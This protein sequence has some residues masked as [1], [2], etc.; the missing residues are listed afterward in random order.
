M[1]A[2]QTKVAT[3]AATPQNS[4]N[5]VRVAF[6]IGITGHRTLSNDQAERVEKVCRS[7]LQ[8]IET[9][10]ASVVSA[11][12]PGYSNQPP[13]VRAISC[14]AAGSDQILAK[15][16]TALNSEPAAKAQFEVCAILPFAAN[17][18]RQDFAQRECVKDT[19][20]D[21][22]ALLAAAAHRTTL[23]DDRST[24]DSRLAA[25]EDAGRLMISIC[26]LLISVRGPTPGFK[27]GGTAQMT[28]EA[29]ASGLPVVSINLSE[30]IEVFL[31]AIDSQGQFR[32][33]AF[34]TVAIDRI[35]RKV[36]EP[37]RLRSVGAKESAWKVLCKELVDLPEPIWPERLLAIGYRLPWAG[38]HVLARSLRLYKPQL[39][40]NESKVQ[41][42]S[43]SLQ[44]RYEQ[45]GAIS[46]HYAIL[47]RGSFMLNYVL[48]ATA[49]TF[50][51]LQ[52]ATGSH[53]YLW[54]MAEAI[55]L[56]LLL[57]NFFAGRY[58][59]W[60]DRFGDFRFLTEQLRQIRILGPLGV[61]LP[62]IQ[63][64]DEVVKGRDGWINWY[65]R[66]ML[67]NCFT[68]D[69]TTV[70]KCRWVIDGW[71]GKQI[72]YHQD[73]SRNRLG[74][75]RALTMCALAFFTLAGLACIVHLAHRVPEEF[76][77]WL[78]LIAAAAPAWTAVCHSI[79]IQG[80]FQTIAER[81]EAVGEDLECIRRDLESALHSG[82]LTNGMLCSKVVEASR[83]MLYEVAG[84]RRV[85]QMHPV[86]PP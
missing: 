47:W 18:Y 25:Y 20:A 62:D 83:V 8:A 44:M 45:A 66:A 49:V 59:S 33:D 79:G 27:R 12:Y 82:Q 10:A 74:L 70:D 42:P 7:V 16:A 4:D 55:T 71:L 39:N 78:I 3:N 22:D 24:L 46:K 69:G 40:K 36:L 60:H 64:S 29:L 58:R 86:L 72:A 30:T 52:Y 53:A 5:S 9:T 26:D 54:T 84:W 63:K 6:R 41:L 61:M 48:G 50:A 85:S 15:V 2:A 56:A 57:V 75:E 65:C 73:Y 38:L 17:T 37:P 11:S 28:L 51:L 43:S 68:V 31:D 1:E 77:P 21:F 14:L 13:L 19:T 76:D 80:E 34:D 32:R 23:L 35:V 81:S 67:R